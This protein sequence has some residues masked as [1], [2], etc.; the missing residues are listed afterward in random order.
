VINV[1][2]TIRR[3]PP[4]FA[5]VVIVGFIQVT[6][7][8]YQNLNALQFMQ[9]LFAATPK[10][11][12]LSMIGFYLS[13]LLGVAGL[14]AV[15]LVAAHRR[16]GLFLG[17]GVWGLSLL[18]SVFSLFQILSMNDPNAPLATLIQTIFLG[19]PDVTLA[20][21][22][23]LTL[24]MVLDLLV[25]YCLYRYLSSEPGRTFFN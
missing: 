2:S 17:L 6:A 5:L 19:R 21:G 20:S 18:L 14:V 22:A 13:M 16:I 24:N 8:L 15:L 7:S 11:A 9:S 12:D 4:F 23:L 10:L 25:L 1:D 3:P